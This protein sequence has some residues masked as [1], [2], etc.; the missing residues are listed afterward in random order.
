MT[1]LIHAFLLSAFC[2]FVQAKQILPEIKYAIALQKTDNSNC[3]V[4]KLKCPADK[5]GATFLLYPN[6]TWGQSN[7]HNAIVS[8]KGLTANTTAE[9][10]K[11]NGQIN[12]KHPANL[13]EIEIEYIIKQDFSDSISAENYYRPIIQNTYF[14]LLGYA[15]LA[16]PSQL[17]SDF[18]A[19]EIKWDKSIKNPINSFGAK[20]SK[21]KFVS[22]FESLTSSIF[23]NGDFKI[24]KH[25]ILDAEL[26]VAHRG[27]W[28]QMDDTTFNGMVYRT[29]ASQRKFWKDNSQKY[30]FISAI[31]LVG[32]IVKDVKG[33]IKNCSAS[34]G[35]TC[36]TS[37]FAA[38]FTNNECLPK[39]KFYYIF[40]HELMHNWI[41]INGIPLPTENEELSYWFSEGF[42]D[43]YAYKNMVKNN[44]MS[45]KEFESEVQKE[46]IQP[47]YESSVKDMPNDSI[48]TNFWFNKDYQKLPYRRGFLI[49]WY[50]DIAIRNKT[51]NFKSLDDFIKDMAASCKSTKEKFNLPKFQ[52][53]FDHFMNEEDM[54]AFVNT[55]IL[56]GKVLDL[57]SSIVWPGIKWTKSLEG[58][59]LKL[60]VDENNAE[61]RRFFYE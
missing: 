19:I 49:A 9:L 20:K 56:Q 51:K 57:E 8:L 34:A 42:T 7:L 38:F 23:C 26:Y 17:K 52:R 43:Y 45:F 58:N 61:L 28:V 4:V 6:E 18:V 60:G 44:F 59:T 37:S 11:T 3:L 14:H 35:G 13:T 16:F 40:N 31:P 15:L 25:K 24:K 47:H 1:R 32:K 55:H 10:D 12:V 5:Y 50:M 53:M 30:F 54:S 27:N 33:N 46:V 2:F 29:V 21:Q 22:R 36:L 48:K 41:G 39:Y